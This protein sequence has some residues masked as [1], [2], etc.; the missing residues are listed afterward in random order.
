MSDDEVAHEMITCKLAVLYVDIPHNDSDVIA[1]STLSILR[2]HLCTQTGQR[3]FATS[4]TSRI[5]YGGQE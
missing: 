5:V 2:C 3:R 1:D 4:Q